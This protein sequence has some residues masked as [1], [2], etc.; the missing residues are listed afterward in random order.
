MNMYLK[1]YRRLFGAAGAGEIEKS[2]SLLLTGPQAV[3]YSRVRYSDNDYIRTQRQRNILLKM[4]SK[5]KMTGRRGMIQFLP[6][7]LDNV[8]TNLRAKDL[9][10]LFSVAMKIDMSDEASV[11]QLRVPVDG[12]FEAGMFGNTWCIK[13]DLPL[14]AQLIKDFIYGE[15]EQN[16]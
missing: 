9:L 12:T 16:N 15:T 5:M 3:A 8:E 2:G 6:I 4:A 1:T 10:E 13:A 14:N 11:A 7:M